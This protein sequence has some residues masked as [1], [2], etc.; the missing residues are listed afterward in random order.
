MGSSGY[1]G[2]GK[3]HYACYYISEA[4]NSNNFKQM[5]DYYPLLVEAVVEVKKLSD[6]VSAEI[7]EEENTLEDNARKIAQFYNLIDG[8]YLEYV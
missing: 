7:K 5:V 8:Y 4:F 2:A 3:I 1:V 6:E